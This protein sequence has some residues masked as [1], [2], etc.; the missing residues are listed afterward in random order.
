MSESD[1]QKKWKEEHRQN[2]IRTRLERESKSNTTKKAEEL[3]IEAEFIASRDSI[4]SFWSHAFPWFLFV[5]VICLIVIFAGE[6]LVL[7]VFF[8]VSIVGCFGSYGIYRKHIRKS[9][10][11]LYSGFLEKTVLLGRP[12]KNYYSAAL[13][14]ILLSLLIGFFFYFDYQWSSFFLAIINILL[15]LFL[16][17]FI[18]I[19]LD[20]FG[21]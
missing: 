18:T 17:L 6:S 3:R 2:R 20:E 9:P 21:W 5:P 14:G 15:Y 12:T 7:T 16:S 4:R 13:I 11:C 8:Y 19:V 1:A 10:M